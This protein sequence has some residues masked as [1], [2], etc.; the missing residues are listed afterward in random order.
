[1]RLTEIEKMLHK[2]DQTLYGE[3]GKDGLRG[4]FKIMDEK[5]DNI[6]SRITTAWGIVIGIQVTA[7]IVFSIL[8]FVLKH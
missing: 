7:A 6:N 5:L 8:Q 3:T 1:M 4:Q 2:H